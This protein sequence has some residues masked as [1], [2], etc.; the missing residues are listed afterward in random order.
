MRNS[1]IA[2]TVTEQLSLDSQISLP[3]LT[4]SGFPLQTVGAGEP[5]QNWHMDSLNFASITEPAA[6]DSWGSS[7]PT[8]KPPPPLNPIGNIF[9]QSTGSPSDTG[10]TKDGVI[11]YSYFQFLTVE[12]LH[13]IPYQDVSY[14]EAQGCLHV[15]NPLILDVFMR[16][17]FTYAHVFKPLV[18][19]GEFW[20]MCS[21]ATNDSPRTTMS[22]LVLRAMLFASSTFVPLPVLRQLGY[23]DICSARADLYRK[24]KLLFDMEAE[25]AHLPLAQAALM[26]MNW[27][28]ESPGTTSPVPYRTWL[29]LAIHHAKLVKAHRHAGICDVGTTANE[30][31]SRTLRRLWWCCIICDRLSSLT[32]RFRLQITPDMLDM[33]NCVPLG[34]ADLQSEIHRSNVFSPATKRQLISLFSKYL[35]LLMLL[36]ELIPVAY[37]FETRLESSPDFSVQ[38]E[39]NIRKSCDLLDEWYD[40]AKAEFPPFHQ[41]KAA[42][43]SDSVNSVA[44]HTN[45]MYIYYQYVLEPPVAMEYG[46]ITSSTSCIALCN[47]RVFTQISGTGSPDFH[48]GDYEDGDRSNEIRGD[49][50]DS[51]LGV[52]KCVGSLTG[53]HLTKYLPIT[54]IGCLAIPLAL[55]HIN[56]GLSYEDEVVPS[57]LK[58]WPLLGLDPMHKHLH[59]VV[60]AAD[61]FSAQYYGSQWVKEAAE[62]VAKLAKSFNK[63]S[64]QSGQEAM[65]DWVDILVRYPET[66]LGLVWTVDMCVSR[67]KLPEAQDFPLC[68]RND[69]ERLNAAPRETEH[70][71][72]DSRSLDGQK[73]LQLTQSLDY[74]LGIQE[75]MVDVI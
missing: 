50:E 14:L 36:T 73:D 6:Y 69:V 53:S 5:W 41:L 24:A 9:Q 32:C 66:Y 68:L 57:H 37:P 11:L 27:V 45:L 55:H 59:V 8:D 18:D 25:T 23:H 17:Y 31:R 52:S 7:V 71:I 15:P 2:P 16:A 30:P 70:E 34:F 56:T 35:G 60:D 67:R 26:L 33:E 43:E 19:E 22:L 13:A 28:P 42:E 21:L 51:V 75:P 44:V 65:K 38:E 61:T 48:R 3:Q 49:I 64:L 40:T 4:S 10:S 72:L 29:S 74:L 46:L 47:R 58:G 1:E 54:V 63:L 20:E 62:H 39:E 12:N